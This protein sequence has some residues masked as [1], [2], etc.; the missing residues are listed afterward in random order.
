MSLFSPSQLCIA[1]SM[2]TLHRKSLYFLHKTKMMT[3]LCESSLVRSFVVANLCTF[4]PLGHS[5]V[6]APNA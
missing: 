3:V 5:M 1:I 2:Y 4:I 6:G